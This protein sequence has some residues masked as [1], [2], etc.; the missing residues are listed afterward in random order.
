MLLSRHLTNADAA[1]WWF[2]VYEWLDL[3]SRFTGLLIE[4]QKLVKHRSLYM[5]FPEI[6]TF[7]QRH[8]MFNIV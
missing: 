5:P 7:D 2:Y 3:G 8:K 6:V 4:S 1:V